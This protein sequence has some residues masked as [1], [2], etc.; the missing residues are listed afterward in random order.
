MLMS[1][2]CQIVF[3]LSRT[4]RWYRGKPWS[5][6][7]AAINRPSGFAGTFSLVRSRGATRSSTSTAWS[8]RCTRWAACRA[9]GRLPGCARTAYSWARARRCC[10]PA[11]GRPGEPRARSICSRWCT[12]RARGRRTMRRSVT[13]TRWGLSG[14]SARR[15]GC[16]SASAGPVL[17]SSTAWTSWQGRRC[18]GNV[19]W[20]SVTSTGRTS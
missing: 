19:A 20:V 11:R 17:T 18:S 14:S 3:V 4:A 1:H 7:R 2:N 13:V 16:C 12:R 5:L 15:R 8:T 10:R 9:S 6:D